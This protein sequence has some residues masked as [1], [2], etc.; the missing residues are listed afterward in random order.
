MPRNI[1][2]FPSEIR[3]LLLSV[4]DLEALKSFV[5]ASPVYHQQ[6]LLYREHLLRQCLEITLGS[7]SLGAFAVHKSSLKTFSKTRTINK[8]AHLLDSYKASSTHYLIPRE[9]SSLD[10]LIKMAN[11]H[12]LVIQPL[13]RHYTDWALRNIVRDAKIL[14]IEYDLNKIEEPFSTAE[15]TRVMRSLYRF[16]LFCNLFGLGPHKLD[17]ELDS[18]DICML[19]AASFDHWELKEISCIHSFTVSKCQ[20][21]FDDVIGGTHP[22]RYSD[23][24]L[25]YNNPNGSVANYAD[26]HLSGTTSRGLAFLQTIFLE[27]RGAADRALLILD[28]F[29]LAWTVFWESNM[30]VRLKNDGTL[31]GYALWDSRPLKCTLKEIIGN[32]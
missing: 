15:G 2:N 11:F 7:I 8:V 31:W 1:E 6:Y 3:I 21:I 23:R 18:L 10:D 16:E 14:Q 27:P 22:H 5:R 25:S 13:V 24:K 28:G 20:N 26:V 19:V 4:M 9:E 29:P 32:I 17:S 12:R 30:I